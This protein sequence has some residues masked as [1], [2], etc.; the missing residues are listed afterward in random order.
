MPADTV[1][2]LAQEFKGAFV[3]PWRGMYRDVIKFTRESRTDADFSTAVGIFAE[4]AVGIGSAMAPFIPE[5]LPI[6]LR[7]LKSSHS[8]SW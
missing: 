7:G 5:C 4:V 6:V 1:G 3:E 2:L 8:A